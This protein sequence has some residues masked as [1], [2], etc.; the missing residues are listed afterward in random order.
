MGNG[1]RTKSVVSTFTDARIAAK[2]IATVQQNDA[3]GVRKMIK[4]YGMDV[5]GELRFEDGVEKMTAVQYAAKKGLYQVLSDLLMVGCDVNRVTP[6]DDYTALHLACSY[7]DA[8]VSRV[9]VGELLAHGADVNRGDYCGRLPLI[10]AAET[11]HPEVVGMLV[12]HGSDVNCSFQAE[13][14][15]CNVSQAQRLLHFDPKE[16]DEVIDPFLNNTALMQACREHHIECVEELLKAGSEINKGN[17]MGNGALHIACMSYSRSGFEPHPLRCSVDG[18]PAIVHLLLKQSHCDINLTNNYKE[19]PLL[20]A[21]W[22]IKNIVQWNIPMEEKINATDN[23][24]HIVEDLTTAGCSVTITRADGST[25]LSCLLKT[26]KSV[27]KYDSQA[28]QCRLC[29]CL[30]L[31]LLAGCVADDADL[32]LMRS[33]SVL[34]EPPG[35]Y[36]CAVATYS[37]P[38]TLKRLC[39]FTIRDLIKRPLWLHMQNTPLPTL[40]QQYLLL[41]IMD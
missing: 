16:E 6:F 36:S 8:E 24:L 37:Q 28:L 19:T 21:L 25:P 41:K 26:V 7:P 23:F 1:Y 34:L 3:K 32:K 22:G 11:G 31:L 2:F 9:M 17:I 29:H 39:K 10:I 30:M 33:L 35:I 15:P 4:K 5:N 14:Y 20:R 18:H 12:T 13:E 38:T 40:L 27:M